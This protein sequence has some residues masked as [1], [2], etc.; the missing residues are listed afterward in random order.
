[1]AKFFQLTA[2]FILFWSFSLFGGTQNTLLFVDGCASDPLLAES[3]ALSPRLG[4]VGIWVRKGDR[5][6]GMK[7]QIEEDGDN[8]IG[9]IIM[10]PSHTRQWG[11]KEGV[12]KWKIFKKIDQ[13]KYTFEDLY[14]I[15]KV[16]GG[17]MEYKET[18]ME[19]ASEHEL[20]TKSMIDMNIVIGAEQIWVRETIQ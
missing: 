11:F 14:N 8:Y 9:R 16:E 20:R 10:T 3:S 12:V 19:F 1:M 7:I 18:Y 6:E 2:Y 4:L 15:G 5:F 17:D 13:G